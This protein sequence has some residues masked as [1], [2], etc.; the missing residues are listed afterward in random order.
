MNSAEQYFNQQKQNQEFVL[1]YNAIS[2]QI[3][4]EWELERVKK[5]IQEDYSKI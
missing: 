1:S 3:D 5:Y 2:K 4:I